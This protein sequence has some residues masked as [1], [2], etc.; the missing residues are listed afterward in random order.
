MSFNRTHAKDF[1]RLDQDILSPLA[2]KKQLYTYETMD[3][4]EQIKTPAYGILCICILLCA[5]LIHNFLTLEYFRMSL[6]CSALYLAQFRQ[7]S[8]GIL[9][10]GDGTNNP[11]V[12]GDVYIHPSAKVH[13]TA[14]VNNHSHIIALFFFF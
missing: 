5:L 8:P 2:G 11:T 4:W 14:K 7:K 9:A 3:F 10:Y 12:V 13:P 6:K 1:V